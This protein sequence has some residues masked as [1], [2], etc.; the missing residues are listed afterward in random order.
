[1]LSNRKIERFLDTFPSQWMQLENTL[2]ATPDPAKARLFSIDKN[3]PASLQM[4]LEPLLLFDTVFVENRPMMDLISPDF[5]HRSDFLKTWYETELKPPSFDP[6][7][8]VKENQDRDRQRK[9]LSETI[10]TARKNLDGLIT[11][12]KID[13]LKRGES[14]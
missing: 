9:E 1:M 5:S 7:E 8:L 12:I 2:A 11:P 3:N 10:E 6:T 13:S 4:I 14:S